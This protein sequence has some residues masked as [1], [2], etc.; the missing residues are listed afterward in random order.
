M[1]DRNATV[2]R[3]RELRRTMSLPEGLLWRELR[4]RPGGFKFR[5]QHPVGA[6]VVDFYCAG[7]KLV[8]EV[9]G[10]AHEMGNQAAHD[11]V[12]DAACAQLGLQTLRIPAS[13]ILKDVGT[14][15]AG[16]VTRCAERASPPPSASG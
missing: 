12:R 8:I 1:R 2:I 9:D 15:V 7:S 3:A 14:A 16:I 4:R 6:M 10:A 13:E 11:A 5:R